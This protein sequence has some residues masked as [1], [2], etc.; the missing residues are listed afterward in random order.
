MLIPYRAAVGM[1]PSV[2][3]H[4]VTDVNGGNYTATEKCRLCGAAR[5]GYG[6]SEWRGG[7]VDPPWV[8]WVLWLAVFGPVRCL[9]C[10]GS[11][12]HSQRPWVACPSCHG[13][14]LAT[15]VE[16]VSM[17]R[18]S[19]RSEGF[20]P[21]LTVHGC[22]RPVGGY[23]PVQDRE[24]TDGPTRIVSD[25]QGGWWLWTDDDEPNRTITGELGDQMV[26]VGMWATRFEVGP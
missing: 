26:K 19:T 17:D 9:E 13:T 7:R 16:V 3:D 22:V 6:Y 18:P 2:C 14:S 11:G 21:L 8:P 4:P 5:D 10:R 23:I 20:R 25:G 12:A 1:F 15:E 24:R